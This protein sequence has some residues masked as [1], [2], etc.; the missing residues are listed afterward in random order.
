MPPQ[1]L[2]DYI[3][4]QRAQ[5]V[6]DDAI[7]EALIKA[8]W[9]KDQIEA[10]FQSLSYDT[11]VNRV[12]ISGFILLL[13]KSWNLYSRLLGK[14]IILGVIG[15]LPVVAS[16]FFIW[17][18]LPLFFVKGKQYTSELIFNELEVKSL[19]S[20][21]IIAGVFILFTQFMNLLG[22]IYLIKERNNNPSVTTV[23]KFALHNY[24]KFLVIF[25]LSTI[26]ILLGFMLL[27]IPGIIAMTWLFFGEYVFVYEGKKGLAALKVSRHLIQGRWWGVFSRIFLF[28]L[29][30]NVFSSIISAVLGNVTEEV[31][32]ESSISLLLNIFMTQF[33]IVY[34]CLL[35]EDLRR[36]YRPASLT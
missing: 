3:L 17:Q 28:G 30:V 35:Y 21:L 14:I 19:I 20:L 18:Y 12:V 6:S 26:F 10:G 7:R 34:Y 25:I 32:I 8:G 23:L 22:T 16:A 31:I 15:H 13:K 5:G 4:S 11:G 27:V 36:T 1:E 9:Q 24:W 33:A 2:T 29:L